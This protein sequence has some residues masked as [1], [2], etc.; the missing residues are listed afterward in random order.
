VGL[1]FHLGGLTVSIKF[2]HFTDLHCPI[3]DAK[4]VAW[5]YDQIA[6]FQ[7]DLIVCGGDAYDGNAWSRWDNENLWTPMDEYEAWAKI[8]HNI[9]T[10]SP[11]SKKV[12]LYGNHEANLQEPGRLKKDLR[13]MVDWRDWDPV[14]RVGLRDKVREWRVVTRYGSAVR[15]NCGPVTFYP[16]GEV[17]PLRGAR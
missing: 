17:Q 4:A 7:P 6:D 14:D 12:W 16:R 10:I 11:N 13:A 15:W 8:V 9:N 2:L 1:F 5:L 3:H